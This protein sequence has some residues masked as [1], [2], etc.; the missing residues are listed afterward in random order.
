MKHPK[1]RVDIEPLSEARWRKVDDVVLSAIDA[2]PSLRPPA[3]A[4]RRWIAPAAA[5]VA[6]A[7]AI[8]VYAKWPS[9]GN[10]QNAPVAHAPSHIE[11]GSGRSFVQLGFAAL[12]VGP[13]SE[14]TTSGDEEHGVLVVLEHGRVDCEVAPRKERPPFVVQA[15]NV[16][17]TVVGTHFTVN[18]DA[19]GT[20]VSVAHGIVDVAHD[21]TVTH[22][23]A[24][25]AWPPPVLPVPSFAPSVLPIPSSAP[26]AS[27]SASLASPPPSMRPHVPGP[28]D[29]S[30]Y[31]RAAQLERSDPEQA[32]AIYLKL[33]EKGGPWA[34]NALFAAARLASERGNA[35]EAQRL[36]KQYLDRYPNGPNA[37]DAR[38]L[39]GSR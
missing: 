20:S 14:I 8:V 6:I 26:P 38:R 36:S 33:S 11:T 15:G 19:S 35:S 3:P 4:K 30:Q 7:A 29:Q 18:R 23:A 10:V 25:E 1:I 22:V 5:A 32:R 17:V 39:S 12:D 9:N 31:E 34:S 28:T 37:E 2:G 16:R 24:G 13:S 21:G 27:T